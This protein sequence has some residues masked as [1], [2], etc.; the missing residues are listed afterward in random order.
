MERTY[1]IEAVG[2]LVFF[3]SASY[4]SYTFFLVRIIDLIYARKWDAS[5]IWK[6]ALYST[7]ILFCVA[8]VGLYIGASEI[9]KMHH[10]AS[11]N[12]VVLVLLSSL[13]LYT[14]LGLSAYLRLRDFFS[15]SVILD[16]SFR[17][18]LFLF[19]VFCVFSEKE[20]QEILPWLVFYSFSLQ[21]FLGILTLRFSWPLPGNNEKNESRG[22]FSAVLHSNFLGYLKVSSPPNDQFLISIFL[23]TTIAGVYAL[24]NSFLA[25]INILRTTAINVILPK[26]SLSYRDSPEEFYN[27]IKRYQKILFIFSPLV[28][29]GAG[30]IVIY[31]HNLIYDPISIEFYIFVIIYLIN[32][33]LTLAFSPHFT[34]GII[35]NLVFRRTIILTLKVFVLIALIH[36]DYLSVWMIAFLE[37]I[38]SIL[39]RIFHDFEVERKWRRRIA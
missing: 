18:F 24:L 28:V 33:L 12:N 10:L 15:L 14:T 38:G 35:E 23:G 3:V 9:E 32:Q 29:L 4:F 37:L 2:E 13:M 5:L 31:A 6:V 11:A 1:G 36:F 22:F 27:L 8:C 17:F 21:F 20:I 25:P 19:I 26:S 39:I 34:I 7:T 30:A 16:S